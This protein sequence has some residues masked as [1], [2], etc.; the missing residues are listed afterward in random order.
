MLWSKIPSSGPCQ[1]HLE[2]NLVCT[3]G[4]ASPVARHIADIPQTII[5]NLLAPAHSSW[6]MS[7]LSE[8][9]GCLMAN[10][11]TP[12]RGE[13]WAES[14]QRSWLA[15]SGYKSFMMCPDSARCLEI[16][17]VFRIST[18]FN[19]FQQ[20]SSSLYPHFMDE[21]INAASSGLGGNMNNLPARA[22]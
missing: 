16:W 21:Q 6:H 8:G 5:W 10:A 15:E 12:T 1:S 4:T 11:S 14:K 3:W 22:I 17:K 7:S 18:Y 19:V 20:W 13:K 9:S 2:E